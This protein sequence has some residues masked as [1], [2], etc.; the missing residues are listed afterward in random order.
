M[1]GGAAQ[2]SK[3]ILLDAMTLTNFLNAVLPTNLLIPFEALAESK[4]VRIAF[5]RQRSRDMRLR[6]VT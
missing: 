1:A 3:P 6:S 4:D 2:M 5:A